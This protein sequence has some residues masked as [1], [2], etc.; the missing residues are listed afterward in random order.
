MVGTGQAFGVSAVI[1][2]VVFIKSDV[3]QAGLLKCTAQDFGVWGAMISVVSTDV[4]V[5]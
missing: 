4:E 3:A 5:V 2:S 1:L